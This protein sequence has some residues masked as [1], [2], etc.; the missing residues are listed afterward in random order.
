MLKLKHIIVATDFSATARNA[1]QYTKHLAEALD[2]RITVL[3]VNEYF[4]PGDEVVVTPIADLEIT[5]RTNT[6][7]ERF[8]AEDSDYADEIVLIKHRLKTRILKGDL[9]E[10]LVKLSQHV[11]TDLIVI[12][13]T[14]AADFLSKIIGSTSMKVAHNA[15]CP[16]VLVPRTAYW[17]GMANIMYASDYDTL[18]P[19][20]LTKVVSFANE[21][22][23]SVH[24]V[25]VADSKE[26]ARSADK[27]VVWDDFFAV[28]DTGVSLEIHTLPG[29]NTVKE[30]KLYAN[31]NDID[32][33]VFV[34]K[35]RSF[36]E[37]II[38]NSVT[39]NIALTTDVPLMLIHLHDNE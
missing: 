31:S 9:V 34:H 12:G 28:S 2:A 1:F 20:L 4:M 29:Q 24:Y 22:D 23:A 10:H 33:M 14:G 15:H 7:M 16:V 38:H 5:R 3:H 26:E 13:M 35:Q 27:S 8:V 30:L 17:R 11:D 39:E 19:A 36:W 21:M 25:H 6:L 32:L 37:N 18:T